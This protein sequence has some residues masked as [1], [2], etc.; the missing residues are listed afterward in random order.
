[1]NLLLKAIALTVKFKSRDSSERK[2]VAQMIFE[3]MPSIIQDEF[4]NRFIKKPYNK[5]KDVVDFYFIKLS[6]MS[7]FFK[8]GKEPP[9]HI[10]EKKEPEY[11]SPPVKNTTTIGELLKNKEK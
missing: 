7:K 6:Q 10:P 4:K 3:D 9:K 11:K 5:D 8:T 2:K 1:M